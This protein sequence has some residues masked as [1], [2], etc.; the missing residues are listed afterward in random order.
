MVSLDMTLSN[1]QIRKALIRLRRSAPLLFTN[2]EDRLLAW[3]P[4]CLFD[5][6]IIS[7]T[8]I[9]PLVKSEGLCYSLHQK[10]SPT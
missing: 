3:K 6:F 8:S 10:P 9:Q 5:I 1:K 4:K 7:D 2:P